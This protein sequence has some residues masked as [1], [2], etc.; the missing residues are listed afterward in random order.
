MFNLSFNNNY[1]LASRDVYWNGKDVEKLG[2]SRDKYIC[3]GIILFNLKKSIIVDNCNIN[4]KSFIHITL[5][6]DNNT[7]YQALVI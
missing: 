4:G 6:I 5:S 2:I 3:A 7:F 1:I